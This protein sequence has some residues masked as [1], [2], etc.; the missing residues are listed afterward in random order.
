MSGIQETRGELLTAVDISR[1]LNVTS[2]R[3][4][5]LWKEGRIPQGLRLGKRRYIRRADWEAWLEQAGKENS[6]RGY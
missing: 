3:V 1:I 4:F 2:G 5:Q 6:N